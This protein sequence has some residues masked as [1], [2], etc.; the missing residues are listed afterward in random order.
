MF[1]LTLKKQIFL[2]NSYIL[3]VIN[4]KRRILKK[5]GVLSYNI[6]L[7][8]YLLTLNFKLLFFF[9]SNGVLFNKSFYKILL[10]FINYFIF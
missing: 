5:L 9:L 8:S 2:K 10:K 6:K 4:N 1:Y 7:N 3:V